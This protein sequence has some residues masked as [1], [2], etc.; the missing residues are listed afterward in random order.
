MVLMLVL[1]FLTQNHCE[2]PV[3]LRAVH[4]GELGNAEIAEEDRC[5]RIVGG[6]RGTPQHPWTPR[7]AA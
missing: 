5:W 3:P 4:L 1:G 6:E 2:P 7:A